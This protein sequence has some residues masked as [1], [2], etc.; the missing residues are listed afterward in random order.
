MMRR[1]WCL[2]MLLLAATLGCEA[3]PGGA[4]L[5]AE[6]GA[7]A[8]A[9][10]EGEAFVTVR[11]EP[12]RRGEMTESIEALGL[13]EALPDHF[14][15]LT[16]AV[17]GHVLT[18]LVKQGDA[19]A[20]GQPIVELDPSVALAD[21]AEKTAS[22]DGLKA[23]LDLLKSLP[24]PEEQ[25]PLTLAIDTA[26]VAL[27]RAERQNSEM[28]KLQE[29]RLANP[30]QLFDAEK[31]EEAARIAL[32]TARATHHVQMIGP[33]RE[34]VAEAQAR[35][36]TA[37]GLVAFSQAHLNFL[38]IR[39][40][41]D[42]VLDSLTC[43]PGQTLSVG[44]AI[45]DVVDARKVHA[46]VWFSPRSAR[47]VRPGQ[48][49]RVRPADES[50]SGAEGL[51]GTVEFV[52]RVADPRTGNLPVLVLVENPEGRLAL[53]QTVRVLIDLEASGEVL[54]VP[55]EALLDLGEGPVFA[56]VR[57]GK[58]ASLHPEVGAARDG[59]VAVSGTDLKEGE[60]VIIEGGYN[61]PEE[62]PVKVADDEPAGAAHEPPG[63]DP[64]PHGAA[65]ETEEGR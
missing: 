35:I 26:R 39:A 48:A 18:L 59:W 4:D 19:V 30:Q 21:L 62:T 23:S 56:V 9:E 50:S 52:G 58:T 38:T 1:P 14:A 27:E 41:I 2:G 49:A 12:A 33:R 7:E 31:A 3:K 64:E 29:S 13:V 10:G 43:H 25:K 40:P 53:G 42:G 55:A 45:G 51:A 44:A 24:R 5:A 60:P 36:A 65:P 17:E 11:A 61:L 20:K 46:A 34:A 8:E 15:T 37:D 28:K 16:P 47:G 32:E 57:D 6:T 54:Q 22:R 63:A